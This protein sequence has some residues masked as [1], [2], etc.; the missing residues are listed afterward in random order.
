MVLLDLYLKGVKRGYVSLN[1][2]EECSLP[3][4]FECEV[5]PTIDVSAGDLVEIKD[6]DVLLFKGLVE[7]KRTTQR[8]DV[9]IQGRDKASIKLARFTT[10]D[11]RFKQTEPL[12]ILKVLITPNVECAAGTIHEDGFEADDDYWF[13]RPRTPPCTKEISKGRMYVA[14]T[15]EG[16]EIEDLVLWIYRSFDVV[17]NSKVRA[18]V[19]PLSLYDGAKYIEYDG[20]KDPYYRVAIGLVQ[21]FDNT[22]LG[23]FLYIGS[24]DGEPSN[25]KLTLARWVGDYLVVD[26]EVPYMFQWD[27]TYEMELI[28]IEDQIIGKI[29]ESG[30][31]EWT[32]VSTDNPYINT[33][34]SPGLLCGGA[35]AEFRSYRHVR[36]GDASATSYP[37]KAW[38]AIDEDPETEWVS[39]TGNP[40]EEWTYYV[41][42]GVQDVCRVSVCQKR[43]TRV[44]IQVALTPDY[45]VTVYDE[46]PVC[47]NIEAV[48]SPSILGGTLRY[49]KVRLFKSPNETVAVSH[50]GLHKATEGGSLVDLGTQTR[51]EKPVD[52]EV[53]Y[54]RTTEAVKRLADAVNFDVWTTPDGK[55]HFGQRG[56]E[57]S[58]T[59]QRGDNVYS[60]DK[61]VE[62]DQLLYKVRALGFG[63]TFDQVKVESVDESVRETYPELAG[64]Q[65]LDM[66][67]ISDPTL[68][69]EATDKVLNARKQPRE[70]L[71]VLGDD[72]V[73]SRTSWNVG[74]TITIKDSEQEI[75]G[76]YRLTQINRH[77]FPPVVEFEAG[78]PVQTRYKGTTL[79]DIILQLRQGI[80]NFER[81]GKSATEAP[82]TKALSEIV[83]GL[84]GG[85]G[86]GELKLGPSTKECDLV[87]INEVSY[88]AQNVPAW[89]YKSKCIAKLADPMSDAFKLSKV[90]FALW[91]VM[92]TELK[93]QDSGDAVRVM[94][95]MTEREPTVGEE[96]ANTPANNFTVHAEL[97][98]GDIWATDYY[99]A[100]GKTIGTQAYSVTPGNKFRMSFW[101]VVYNGYGTERTVK[102]YSRN[103]RSMYLVSTSCFG[104]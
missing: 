4:T 92:E 21:R 38:K 42:D 99:T 80:K 64:E 77:G 14:D 74:D 26:D 24:E 104:A 97:S 60:L 63:E 89:S 8:F 6:S 88:E 1:Q 33:H 98:T 44:Q 69:K 9:A 16:D 41:G 30:Q 13:A 82:F 18:L 53:R 79:R 57:K 67:D 103:M 31:A 11:H 25:R 65:T 58:V 100:T 37:E 102:G 87:Q 22:P 51:Y 36:Y 20:E 81:M 5:D 46:T 83:G 90:A 62:T 61:S 73:Y 59:F 45:Y 78:I 101:L 40:V 34:G 66:K 91:G 75:D 23:F 52:F 15:M 28:C 12:E 71:D 43:A 86:G 48:F 27:T 39:G 2:I 50:F 76:S 72:D 19:K 56:S 17:D 70:I 49:F 32:V 55:L 96:F 29:R 10:G 3:A 54:D 35:R 93:V 68:L 84:G 7:Q 94:V 95:I 47:P 85:G